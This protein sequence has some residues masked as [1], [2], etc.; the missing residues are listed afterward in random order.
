MGVKSLLELFGGRWLGAALA[1]ALTFGAPLA[2]AQQEYGAYHFLYPYDGNNKPIDL[3]RAAVGSTVAEA[4]SKR[5]QDEIT[6]GYDNPVHPFISVGVVQPAP[7][8]CGFYWL[9]TTPDPDAVITVPVVAPQF[10]SCESFASFPP[11]YPKPALCPLNCPADQKDP[12]T[13]LCRLSSP[14]NAGP[15]CPKCGNPVNPGTG[16]KFQ[17]ET[18]LAS[19]GGQLAFVRYYNSGVPAHDSRLGGFWLHTYNSRILVDAPAGP[20]SAY[21]SDGRQLVFTLQGPNWIGQ[22]DIADSLTELKNAQGTTTG[23]RYF[24]AATDDTEHYDASGRLTAIVRRSGL[25]QTLTYT[26]GTNGAVSGN[27][28]FAL[29]TFGNPTSTI[30][31]R[32]LLLRVRDHV[33]RTLTFGY[34]NLWRL[35]KVTDP[36]GG[37]F[38]YIYTLATNGLANLASVT[39]PDG[40]QRLYHYDEAANTSG[41]S[42]PNALTGITDENGV[43]FSTYKY[44]S[45]G[46]AIESVHHADGNDVDRHQLAY[47]V[48]GA[49]TTV[50]DPL[51][52]ARTYAFQVTLGV[53]KNTALSAPG[54]GALGAALSYDANGNVSSRTD[55]NGNRTNYAYDPARNLETSRTEGLT[56]A[57][58]PTPQTRTTSTQW[59][60]TFRL[61]A[62][63]AQPLRITTNVYDSNGTQCGAR[64]AL[65][66]RSVQATTDATGAQGFSATASGAPRTW[67]YTYNA[68]GSV[69]T[70]NGPRT[71]VADVT[72][73]TYYA[74]NDADLG[75]RGNVATITNAAGHSSSITA[76]NAHGQPL[77]M[78]DANGLSTTMTYDER[79][80]LKTRT[81]GI[82]T[83]TYDY[84]FVGQLI[85]ITLPD[86]SFISYTYDGAHRLTG[87]EDNLGNRIA[88]TLDPMGNRT[89]EQV[90]DPANQLAQTR[91]RVYSNLNRL[92]QELGATG[93]TTEYTYD[94]QGNVLTVKDPLNRLST[95][96]YDALNRLWHV[97]SPAPISAVTQYAYN[98]LDALTQVTDPRSLV[99]GYTVD[100]LGNLTQQASPDTGTTVNTYDA[101]GNLLTQTDAKSQ[102][103]TYAYDA[104]NRVT[105]ITF[106]D[107]SKQTYAYDDQPTN[108]IGRL[109]S[110][111]E[112]NP[113][114]QVTSVLVYAY[115]QHGR[116]LSETRTVNGVPYVLGYRYDAFGRLDQLTYPSGRTVNYTFDGGLLV[117][118]TTTKPG[119]QPQTVVSG[120]TYHPFGGVRSY[121]L[122]NTQVYMRGIDL[123]GRITSYT[124]G[125]ESFAIGYDQA[126]RIEFISRFQPATPPNI[127][128]YG[129]DNLDRLTS[130]TLATTPYT[131]A[132]DS[133]GNRTSKTSGAS[134]DTY[135]YSPT[136]NRI[137]SITPSSGPVKSFVFDP[138]GSTTADGANTYT[139]DVR[140][141]MVQAT[142]SIGATSYQVNALGQRIRKTNTLGDTV[143]HYDT[144][145]KLIAETSPGG[146]LKRELIYLGD[147]PVGVVQ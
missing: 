13:G 96:Q 62:V 54:A 61:P 134:T 73:Y 28:G 37:S 63:I 66:A 5:T 41:T 57:G 100:G 3:S 118:V 67:T 17:A 42:K 48:S 45:F 121:T 122:G 99:T 132:Y 142:S 27:G 141:R 85:K 123:D 44:D 36:A 144:Q 116:V 68:N 131:Y 20:A 60:T 15:P 30:L 75:K 83:T 78:V 33:G 40:R 106:H 80:R 98:G 133:V 140:G 51:G 105:L 22:A 6:G 72:T 109:F 129:Y 145:G 1:V 14:K 21:R 93:Q 117:Q 8:A 84:D 52:M 114:N 108:G 69:L 135:T 55:F 90:R 91:G 126:S 104:L 35:K 11:Q 76:Y 65:C 32:G 102:V 25:S 127:N 18:D 92:F 103:T 4:C 64:G 12:S 24:V 10:H 113:A 9:N 43:R 125:S 101:A 88:Y 143:F 23:W 138:N 49:Q 130:A 53:V 95:N 79:L 82:E 120:V 146:A 46:R 110:I 74:N 38:L 97:T 136:S 107:G 19:P 86:G 77:S 111:T 89:A 56:A 39:Y 26:D 124:L 87:M 29:D 58:G 71:D 2:N 119:D 7:P 50:T 34:T 16:N 128:T 70:A 94:D 115:D 137:A 139:Y 81:V 59:D 147:I 31:D 112:T 47:N